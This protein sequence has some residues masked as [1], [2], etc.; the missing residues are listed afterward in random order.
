ME[1]AKRLKKLISRKP[2][3]GDSRPEK[4]K[5]APKVEV[6]KPGEGIM[7]EL[8]AQDKRQRE[9]VKRELMAMGYSE[10]EAE[11]ILRS[12]GDMRKAIFGI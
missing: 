12:F 10:R 6:I 5:P 9:E 2:Q 7:A 3:T 4:P 1:L 8:M 11:E